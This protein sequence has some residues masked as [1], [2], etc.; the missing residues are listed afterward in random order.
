MRGNTRSVATV[1]VALCAT[2]SLAATTTLAA[3]PSIAADPALPQAS[4]VPGGVVLVDAGPASATGGIAPVVTLNGVRTMVV[5]EGDHWTAV[6]GLPLS[7]AAPATVDVV[8]KDR[9]GNERRI[10]VALA[11]KQ[12]ATQRLKVKPGQ[13]NLSKEDLARVEAER[14]RI[15]T[16]LATF[17]PEPPATLALRQP[18]PGP[19]SSSFGLRRVFNGE[20]RNPHSGMDIAAPTGTP[21]AAPADGR[22][23][24]TG[25][26]FF[27]GNTILVDHGQGLVTMYCHLS[28]IDVT[29]GQ[30]VRTGEPIGKVGATGRVTG[31]HLHW[32][33]TLNRASVDPALFLPRAAPAAA[34]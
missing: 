29:P 7:Q 4:E 26:F 30:V 20:A 34:R 23:L 19:R 11:G 28:A 2:V 14:V 12:Y 21:I 32:G 17:S 25:N 8:V 18:V 15:L 27:N 6:V 1:A 3:A 33:V 22:V 16:A 31:P 24:D 13:V 5:R 10:G 9:D